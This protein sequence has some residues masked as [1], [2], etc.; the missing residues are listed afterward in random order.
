M[1]LGQFY[2]VAMCTKK[3]YWLYGGL[4]D[5]GS[6]GVPSVGLKGRGP[7]NE[8]VVSVGGGDGFVCRVDP[9]DPDVVYSESQG[10]AINRRNLR[11]GEKAA[12]RPATEGGAKGAGAGGKK[13]K[14]PDYRWNWN[15]PMILSNFNSKI[16]YTAANV[17][18][19]SLDRGDDL[20]AI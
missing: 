1:A 4:Q 5:N 10:G 7:I 19:K 8:D 17:V 18:F 12:I 6:W 11:T 14:G 20:R 15:T 3:P 2:H 16:F 13:G 9:N